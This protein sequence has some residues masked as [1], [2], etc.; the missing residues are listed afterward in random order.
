MGFIME[1]L[2][3]EAYDRTYSDRQLIDRIAQYFSPEKRAIGLVTAMVVLNSLLE[4]SLPILVASGLDRV[5]GDDNSVGSDVWWIVAA[6][7]LSSTAAWGFNFVRQSTS[8]RVVGNIVLRLRT[9]AIKAVM[10]RDMSFFDEFSSGKV[11]SRVTSD[12]GD[13]S[14]TITLV[15][16]LFSQVLIVVLVTIVLFLRSPELTVIV[17]LLVPCIV[18]VALGFRKV[19]RDVTIQ[20]QRAQAEVNGMIQETMRGISVA[21]SYRQE[22]T[23]YREFED[24]NDR[25][26]LVRLKQG[27][28]FSGIFPLL[29]MIAGFG[30]TALVYWGGNNVI[31]GDISAGDWYLFLQAVGLF[32]LP[33]T[34]IASFWSQFQQGLSA[35]ERVFA[36]I[37]AEA[38]VTQTD[39]RDPGRLRGKVE[40]RNVTFGYEDERPILQHFNLTIAAGETI[41]LVGH[42]GAGKSTLGRL[43]SRFYEFQSG[44]IL[45]DDMDIRTFDLGA[46]RR[47]LGVVPQLPFLFSGT[48]AD[49]IR[50]AL[51]DATDEQIRDAAAHIGNGDWVDALHDGLDTPIGEEGRGLSMGQRQLVALARVLIQDPAIIILDEATASVDPLTETQIQ[52]GL[53]TVMAGRTSIVIAHRLSTIREVDRIIVLDHGQIVEEGSH[54]A[55]MQAGGRYADLY[56]TYF[57]HQSPD[58][59][60]GEGFVAVAD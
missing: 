19:A 40:F 22:A 26:Y 38:R 51:P 32:W 11:V 46:Y 8:A 1:G 28:I 55:L 5:V 10:R 60:P 45:I 18:A 59:R 49:N 44:H 50:Y 53:D 33:Q 6:I 57:R 58:Y 23:I 52:E 2:D 21:K 4:A 34:S 43:I 29:F 9:D 37:D 39:N 42:T 35:S 20:S 48:V 13:F 56:N 17:L 54:I 31:D 7:F 41:A 25:T 47:Q 3:A 27:F 24:I 12:T 16:S 14:Q 36:L 30:T 15:L